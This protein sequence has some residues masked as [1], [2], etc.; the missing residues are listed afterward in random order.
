VNE[1]PR[2]DAR[3][4]RSVFENSSE[5]VT[6][7][8]SDGTLRYASPAFGR[9]LGYDPDEAV[10]TMNVLDHVHPDDLSLVLEETQ[11]A[12]SAGG[13]A[14]NKV[15]YRFRHKEGY[16]R[17]VESVG[18][19]LLDDPDVRGV[20]VQTRDV[21][22]RKEAQE[23]LAESEER[24]R[25]LVE[26][27][28]AITYE[29][30]HKPGEFSGTTYVSP[31][32]ET[33]L[34]YTQEEYTAEPEFWKTIVHPGDRERVLAEDERTGS[35]GEAFNLEYR[36]ISKDGRVVWLRE[37]GTLVRSEGHDRQIWHGVMFDITELKR[38]EEDLR[39][40]EARYRTLVERVP[41]IIYIQRLR[42]GETAAYDTTYMSPRVE[43]LLGYPPGRFVADPGFWD[44][45]I[46]SVD[47]ERVLAEDER[48]D[49]TGEPFAMEYRMIT[50][51]GRLVWVRDEATLVRDEAGEPLYWLGV[52]M[53]IT[54]RKYS[55]QALRDA[56]ERYRSLVE[57]IPAVTYIDCADG[58]EEPLYTSPQIEEMLGYTPEEWLT[59]KLWPERLHP[60]DRERVLAA[61]ERFESGAAERFSE[62][63]RLIAK[64]GSVVWCARMR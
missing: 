9:M 10:G 57:Q 12:L 59:G 6:I 4:L 60:D 58:S 61:D 2:S 41:P 5:N 50:K 38:V 7:V 63:Y 62:E 17:W 24:Y 47:R 32:V 13:V 42:E 8:E 21:T 22:E 31:Q 53:D 35:T 25:T 20:V 30:V 16:W 56:E 3:W 18:T 54:D 27:V 28:P 26:R 44:S 43:D 40:A 19:Y 49:R 39:E 64:D 11:K 23:R 33:I 14:T 51:N 36:M 37:S 1:L 29:H 52:Q 48:T 15:E 34:G 45:L 55:E 46:Y